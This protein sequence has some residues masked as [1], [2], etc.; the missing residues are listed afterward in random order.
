MNILKSTLCKVEI[1]PFKKVDYYGKLW[2][3]VRWANI[4]WA[5]VLRAIDRCGN[6][7]WAKVLRP[8][9][10]PEGEDETD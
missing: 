2:G 7:R 5:Y 9:E 3:N 10:T 8:G 1:L 6:V 4:R